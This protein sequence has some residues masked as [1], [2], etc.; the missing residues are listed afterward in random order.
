MNLET[1]QQKHL[2]EL[3]YTR[4]PFGKY[5][6]YYLSDIPEPYYVWF[7]QKGF[8]AS[9]IGRQLE[10]MYEIK[11]NGLEGLFR[12]IRKKVGR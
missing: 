9:K 6:G 12:E 7:K 10:E 8:P 3:A 11:L 5:Q 2:V 1:E 4:M